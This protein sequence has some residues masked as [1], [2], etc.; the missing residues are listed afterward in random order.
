MQNKFANKTVAIASISGALFLFIGT[1]LHPMDADPNDAL[2]A[3]TEYADDHHWVASHLVQLLGVIFMVSSL[4]VLGT[5]FSNPSAIVLGKIGTGWAISV[6]ALAGALQA[7]D[8]IALKAMVNVWASAQ[9]PAQSSLFHATL[10]VRQIEIGL[11]SITSLLTGLT[12]LVFGVALLLD[13]IFPKWVGALA[14][15]SGI[16][17]G[18]AGIII[19]YTGFSEL[20][21]IVNMPASFLLLIWMFCIGILSWRRSA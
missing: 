1:Y 2:A 15:L 4:L 3:F 14:I 8:G 16:P 19:G 9:P 17:T 21:M 11:A 7:V 5:L 13:S 12:I 20:S 18:I 6:L 10:G